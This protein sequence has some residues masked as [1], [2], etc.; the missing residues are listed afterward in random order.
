MR[1][2]PFCAEKIQEAAVACRHCGR[3]V[4]PYARASLSHKPNDS[5][6]RGALLTLLLLVVAGGAVFY[7][8][9]GPQSSLASAEPHPPVQPPR[10][11][12]HDL[13][14]GAVEVL[15]GSYISWSWPVD[16]VR[17]VCRVQV[18]VTGVSGGNRDFQVLLL[19]DDGMVNLAN[20]TAIEAHLRTPQVSATTVDEAMRGNGGKYHLVVSNAFSLVSAKVVQLSEGSVVCSVA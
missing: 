5:W 1:S 3:D 6:V 15:A 11:V 12:Q 8:M 2:C 18:R 4:M 20:G 7:L 16:A 13:P 19:D 17:R 10:A 9:N 14:A